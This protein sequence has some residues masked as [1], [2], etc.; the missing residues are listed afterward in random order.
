MMSPQIE[1][2]WVW[3]WRRTQPGP[4][5]HLVLWTREIYQSS[6]PPSDEDGA[7]SSTV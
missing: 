7:L 5:V 6:R 1:P 3:I 4:A 2:N